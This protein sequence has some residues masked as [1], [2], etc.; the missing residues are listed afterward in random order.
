MSL[1]LVAL[2]L[3]LTKKIKRWSIKSGLAKIDFIKIESLSDNSK[4]VDLDDLCSSGSC[5]LN[6]DSSGSASVNFK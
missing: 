1:I 3:Y 2:I 6:E 4:S 5:K